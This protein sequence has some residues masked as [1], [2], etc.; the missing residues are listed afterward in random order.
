MNAMLLGPLSFF[1]GPN[2]GFQKIEM[3]N[4]NFVHAKIR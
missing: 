3:N 4:C 1:R 2:L